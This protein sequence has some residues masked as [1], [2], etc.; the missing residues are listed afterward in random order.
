MTFFEHILLLLKA[1]RP[2]GSWPAGILLF[3][4]GLHASGAV[5]SP[6][7]QIPMLLLLSLVVFGLNDVYDYDTDRRSGRKNSL[8]EG[9]VLNKNR[10]LFVLRACHISAVALLILALLTRNSTTILTM[11][12]GIALAYA[13]SAPPVRLKARPIIDSFSNALG[14]VVLLLLGFSYGGSFAQFPV[15]ML[16]A[17]LMIAGVHAIGAVMDYSADSKSGISTIATRFGRR[18][19]A[20]FSLALAIVVILFS[21]IQS[22]PLMAM[23]WF[24][25]VISLAVMARP[26]K[27]FIRKLFFYAYAPTLLVMLLYLYQQF[28]K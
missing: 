17:S 3:L 11:A 25:A 19:A 6:L 4:I 8:L 1:S 15:K 24:W 14:T 22:V 21:G 16:Y 28:Y 10:Q 13:Y 20:L 23:V 18:F 26:N 9:Y 12:G 2:V 5:L 7:S 27:Q